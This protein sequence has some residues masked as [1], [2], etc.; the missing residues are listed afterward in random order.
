MGAL[1][2]IPGL[3]D[4]ND[5][6]R[7]V[8]ASVPTS[9]WAWQLAAG[10]VIAGLAV[11]ASAQG[12][13]HDSPDRVVVRGI[14]L[15]TISP[16][17]SFTGGH[18]GPGD[19]R[20][21]IYR[22]NE[23]NLKQ[24]NSK[25]AD[26]NEGEVGA[27]G[28]GTSG[29]PVVLSTGNKVEHELD[30]AALG[31]H[32]LYLRR[33]YNNKWKG[34]GLFGKHWVSNFDY[35]LTFGT[36]TVDACYP[37]PGGG[38]CGLG[39]NT[40]IWAHRPDGRVIKYNR[41]VDGIFYEEK[42]SPLSKIVPQPDGGYLLI[43]EEQE[44][45]K[46][47]SAGYV[48]E[49]K[50][51]RDIGWTFTYTGTYPLRVTHT[52]GRYVEFTWTSGRLSAVRDPAGNYY[53]FS[54]L[55]DRFGP[56]LHLLSAVSRPG[57]PGTDI[58]YHY[59]DSR[60]PGA[61]TG[62]TIGGVRY[63][64]V[65]YNAY[66]RPIVVHHGGD[67][68]KFTFSFSGSPGVDWTVV[69][70]NPLGRQTT[71]RFLEG[72]PY[73]VTGH[74]SAYCAGGNQTYTYDV[75]GNP[76]RVTDFNGIVTDYDYNA[77]GQLLRKVE[78]VGTS[79]Q[80]TTE[81]VLDAER[82]RVLSETIVGVRRT[83]YTYTPDGRIETVSVANLSSSGVVGQ[84]LV[85]RY[86]YT[87]H[88][89]GLLASIVVD[90]PLEGSG[91]ALTYTLSSEGDLLSVRNSLGH[92]T[93]Y[94]N[95]NGLGQPG[96]IVGP[97]GDIAEYSYDAQ[98]RVTIQ[99]GYPGG[100]VADTTYTY[101][102]QGLV[103]S[104]ATPDGV[105]TFYEYDNSRRLVR[106]YRNAKGALSGGA[107][108][109]DELLTYNNNG[110]VTRVERRRWVG[111]WKWRCKRW[112]TI[113]GRPECI[114]EEYVWTLSPTTVFSTYLDYDELGRVRAWRGNS[115][116]NT[117]YTYDAKGNVKT[118]TD[119][120]NRVTSFDYDAL[121]RVVRSTDPLNGTTGFEYDVAGR[122]VRVIDPRG[123]QTRYV[124]DGLGFL[125]AQHSP[126]TGTT[127]FEYNAFGQRRSMRRNDG[128]VTTYSYDALG[129]V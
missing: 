42:A 127:T 120:L 54:Y 106:T 66:Q 87:R 31:E 53:G 47:S 44:K 112:R 25:D 95:Y 122:L 6:R 76:D 103:A 5:R 29:N 126:D 41:G 16:S 27:N 46:Y 116:Q 14:R 62:K 124:Y 35:K 88:P 26:C 24:D 10:L 32:A 64:W 21:P 12:R 11:V 107:D 15:L 68:D 60:F 52:S 38:S 30:F 49:V 123:L 128:S 1:V 9:K 48:L 98:G 57:A 8:A 13:I 75:N 28:D 71:Y 81:Y 117:R 70:T 101:N 91:D 40:V 114:E 79:A 65:S 63:S 34:V 20:R 113:E 110:D 69:E 118:V 97:N 99:R 4:R 100:V 86:T 17:L 55:V 121:D 129:K 73:T 37:R 2:K 43:G 82:N 67:R 96:R 77:K 92:E 84:T 74:P 22:A 111:G 109:E 61:L 90:G 51:E 19:A 18:R 59:E 119:A 104:V 39:A 45:Q 125:W 108:Q 83:T 80:R 105:T 36:N 89:N 56:G 102:P 50:N 78:A 93:I 7:M 23:G 33:V 115:G 94:S 58:A 72:M 3:G 85:T